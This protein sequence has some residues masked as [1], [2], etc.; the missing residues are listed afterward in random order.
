MPMWYYNSNS[1]AVQE[2]PEFLA[3]PSLH[4]GVGYHGPFP[5]KQAA[6]DYYSA[7]KTANPGWKAPTGLAGNIGNAASSSIGKVNDAIGDPLG[8]FNIAG[9]FIR[10]GEILLG[11]ILV[12]V[13]VAKLTGTTNVVSQLVKA[14]IP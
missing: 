9:W 2:F 3:A 14:K 6:L 5:T 1:G 7:N 12:G 8:K 11:L 10:V 4:A 13:G